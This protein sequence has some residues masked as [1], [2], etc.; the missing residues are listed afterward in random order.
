MV[1]QWDVMAL[2]ILLI[3]TI[4]AF[5]V[6]ILMEISFANGD[7]QWQMLMVNSIVQQDWH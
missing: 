6:S 1:W 7:Q 5:N 3:P 2:S 4:I